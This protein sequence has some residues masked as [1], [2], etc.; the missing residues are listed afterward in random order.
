MEGK[1][2]I[3][4]TRHQTGESITR[5]CQDSTTGTIWITAV[6][7]VPAGGFLALPPLTG[8]GA[9]GSFGKAPLID[10]CSFFDEG[11]LIAD[12]SRDKAFARRLFGDLNH[13]VLVPPSD[14]KIIIFSDSEEEE[15]VHEEKVTNVK[16]VS[17]SAAR[18]PTSTAS[19]NGTYKSNTPDR[20]TGGC[21]SGGDEAGLS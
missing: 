20:A 13:D 5:R 18:S 3:K 15:E 16:A 4:R 7:D 1:R 10:L 6:V 2:G 11:D 17:S 8:V 12:V 19:T 21:N 14:C 9:R